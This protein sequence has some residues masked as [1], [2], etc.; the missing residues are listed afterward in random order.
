MKQNVATNG[1]NMKM[2]SFW[3]ELLW[4]MSWRRPRR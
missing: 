1:C 4:S 3:R 2:I